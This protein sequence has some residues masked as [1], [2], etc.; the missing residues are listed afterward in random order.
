MDEAGAYFKSNCNVR[1][2]Y[3]SKLASHLIKNYGDTEHW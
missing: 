1:R 3:F 2:I